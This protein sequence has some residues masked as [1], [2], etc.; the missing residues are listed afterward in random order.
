MGQARRSRRSPPPYRHKAFRAR[1]LCNFKARRVGWN[2]SAGQP[3]RYGR[4]V[5][6]WSSD[7]NLGW[8]AHC[9]NT[10]LTNSPIRRKMASDGQQ[11]PIVNGGLRRC[12]RHMQGQGTTCR[13][14]ST[15]SWIR[16][17]VSRRHARRNISSWCAGVSCRPRNRTS[18]HTSHGGVDCRSRR[19]NI[20]GRLAPDRGYCLG[21]RTSP[22]KAPR[23][24][25]RLLIAF[26][27]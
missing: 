21:A 9:F 24:V 15:S 2:E 4:L 1:I 25:T 7:G 19:Y 13:S 8:H 22:S 20:S 26:P 17:G 3:G 27:I 6:P 5:W 16:A 18:T 12:R 10:L 14:R 11:G 23:P